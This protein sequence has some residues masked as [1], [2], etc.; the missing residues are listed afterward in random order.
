MTESEICFRVKLRKANGVGGSFW[1]GVVSGTT[2][3]AAFICEG[4][5]FSEV[6]RSCEE[7]INLQIG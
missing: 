2:T 1:T 4:K 6:L 5:T 7:W 3:E